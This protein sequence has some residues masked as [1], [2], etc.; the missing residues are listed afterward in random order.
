MCIRHIKNSYRLKLLY[1][2]NNQ[3]INNFTW[4]SCIKEVC[5][6]ILMITLKNCKTIL[7]PTPLITTHFPRLTQ[8][9]FLRFRV[10]EF[11]RLSPI[12]FP[13][14]FLSRNLCFKITAAVMPTPPFGCFVTYYAGP[15]DMFATIFTPSNISII[16][17]KVKLHLYYCG[18]PLLCSVKQCI[19]SHSYN[20]LTLASKNKTIQ[21]V[22][23]HQIPPPH[24]PEMLSRGLKVGSRG[25]TCFSKR[26]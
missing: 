3:S 26:W 9:G 6:T 5:L 17:C 16:T 14:S 15:L 2:V 13:I 20:V 11:R 12:E 23:F 8:C 24:Y 4:I 22:S 25:N 21:R 18:A 19:T 10:E 7:H 1:F